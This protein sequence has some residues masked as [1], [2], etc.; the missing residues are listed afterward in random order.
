M[1]L[2][3]ISI[4]QFRGSFDFIIIL[5]P[6]NT[7]TTIL[8]CI[9]AALLSSCSSR[10]EIKEDTPSRE[11]RLA[12]LHYENSSGEK[13]VTH[14]YYD[15]EGRNYMAIWHLE[16][17]SRSSVNHHTLDSAGRMIVKSREFSDGVRS[18]QHF[19][20]G[21]EGNLISEDFSRSDGVNGHSEYHYGPDGRLEFAD[22]RGLNGWFYGRIEYAWENGLRTGA[23]LYKDSVSIGNIAYEYQDGRLTGEHW[24]LSGSWSQT[25]RYE[26][27]ETFPQTC[28]SSNVFVREDPWY[29]VRSEFY[30]FDGGK[31][32]PSAGG[33]TLYTYDES[34]RLIS[35]EYIRSDGLN[36]MSTYEYDTLGVL[37]QSHRE[38]GGGNGMDFVYWY[39]V[40]RK[41]LVKT[42]T[43]ED[44]TSGSETYRYKDGRLVRGEYVNVDGW[45]N[46]TL[47][48]NC[49]GDGTVSSAVYSGKD[50]EEGSVDF[51]YDL[52]FNLVKIHWAFGSG[53]T[54]TYW[55]EYEA[56]R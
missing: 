13:A 53:Q 54:Q 15:A 4:P 11:S 6:M 20:Y 44:G 42:F 21:P 41:L 52:N 23:E 5:S 50:G 16:D 37:V 49:E 14:F 48:F 27:Q 38:Y 3:R 10:P 56:S 12:K 47:E 28:V 29:R 43:S 34:G 46:G 25:F 33:P 32:G 22:C 17:S 36:T 24:D 19:L 30:T 7:R 1:V 18:V 35:R 39:N 9:F 26:Y 45:L 8:L 51:T 2:F 31:E 55:Y 40:E